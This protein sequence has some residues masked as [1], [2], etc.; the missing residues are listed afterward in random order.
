MYIIRSLFIILVAFASA[1]LYIQAQYVYHSPDRWEAIRTLFIT[2]YPI[3]IVASVILGVFV[4]L[5]FHFHKKADKAEQKRQEQLE[6]RHK[7]LLE[8]I[9]NN[10]TIIY[11]RSSYG[12]R[13]QRKY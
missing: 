8:A 11:R 3:T 2:A 6:E 9:K 1:A 10:R 4:W 12:I 13:K 5:E 7:E